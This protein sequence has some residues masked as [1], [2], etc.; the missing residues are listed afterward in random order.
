MRDSRLITSHLYSECLLFCFIFSSWKWFF[1]NFKI[2]PTSCYRHRGHMH[3]L[4]VYKFY[5][6]L[7]LWIYTDI[8]IF[9]LARSLHT[10]THTHTHMTA[11]LMG[12]LMDISFWLLTLLSLG[13]PG[14]LDGKESA[15]N[16]GDPGSIPGLGKSPGEG[17]GNPLQ[18][19]C[20][21]IPDRGAWQA[22]VYGSQRVRHDWTI[23]THI[24]ELQV[25]F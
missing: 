16:A 12:Q 5:S 25:A 13:F 3:S 1:F 24:S 14:G 11:R 17:N 22:I 4:T 9:L 2:V 20:Q 7:S 18:Y 21:R 8:F 6:S 23:H 10:H 19:S 15:W